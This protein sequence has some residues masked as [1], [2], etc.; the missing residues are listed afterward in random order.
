MSLRRGVSILGL[1]L[2]LA[3]LV[4]QF[5]I[6]IPAFINAGLSAP[7]AIVKYFS[8]FTILTNIMLVLIYLS[9]LVRA[10]WLGW[11]RS[12]VTRG[13]MAGAI[14]LVLL[15]YHFV[16]APLWHPEGLFLVCDVTLHYL[17]PSLYVAWWLF[18]TPHGGLGWRNIPAMLLPP[19][20]YLIY[21]MARGAI[22]ADYP[23]PILEANTL[24]YAQ[25]ALN[26]LGVLVGLTLLYLITVGLDRLLG[27]TRPAIV[28]N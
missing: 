15:F 28:D 26:C 21:V 7:G 27:R 22:V 17:T 14:T 13:M 11:F 18:L 10:A 4:L 24:G 2:G 1:L 19:L 25:V 16:L 8:Y 20:L 6:S 3:G 23:Y 5:S 9:D 12:P